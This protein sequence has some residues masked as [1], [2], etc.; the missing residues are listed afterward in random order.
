MAEF[1]QWATLLSVTNL[2]PHVRQLV[3]LPKERPLS[4]APGQWVSLK[5][6][7]GPNPPLNRAY[8]MAAPGTASGELTLILDRVTDGLGSGYLYGLSPGNAIQLSGPYGNFTLPSQLDRELLF[9]GR[10]TGL[11]PIRCMLKQMYAH[12]RMDSVL[13]IAVA[14]DEDD[15]LFHH[16]FLTLAIHHPG[17][18]YLPLVAAGGEQQAVDLVLSMLRPLMN[19]GPQMLPMLCGTKQFVRPLRAYFVESG[20]ERKEVKTETYD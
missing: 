2:T 5:L 14:P 17:F 7:V 20:Y 8:S 3:L 16:E 4:F 11:V 10:F 18:R 13:L 15:L 12:H 19:G 1:T 6:P 9:I